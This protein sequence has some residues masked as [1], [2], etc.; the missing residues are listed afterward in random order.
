MLE[1]AL[2]HLLSTAS[3]SRTRNSTSHFLGD[4]DLYIY[5]GRADSLLADVYLQIISP[6]NTAPL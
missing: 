3:T 2:G 6:T 5:V 4:V 1:L